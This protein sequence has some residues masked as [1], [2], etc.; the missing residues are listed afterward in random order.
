MLSEANN[1]SHREQ[2]ENGRHRKEA[3]PTVPELSG[4][5]VTDN[6]QTVLSALYA[7]IPLDR[8]Y[9]ISPFDDLRASGL[10]FSE[11]PQLWEGRAVNKWKFANQLTADQRAQITTTMMQD[12]RFTGEWYLTEAEKERAKQYAAR[13]TE[14][15]NVAYLTFLAEQ[16]Y[17]FASWKPGFLS[18]F[19]I[20]NDL[21]PHHVPVHVSGLFADLT[22]ERISDNLIVSLK[23]EGYNG[24]FIRY[25]MAYLPQAVVWHNSAVMQFGEYT[26]PGSGAA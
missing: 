23:Q 9:D 2:G 13:F 11:A 8:G 22:N 7:G 19:G 1:F 5:H 3:F 26:Q 25:N 14:K 16:P 6:P 10:Y 4:Y 18:Q 12:C 21:T 15:G 24:A 17:N 20:T